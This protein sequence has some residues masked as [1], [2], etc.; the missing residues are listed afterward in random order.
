MRILLVTGKIAEDSLRR[1]ASGSSHEV[2]VHALPVSVA[3]FITPEYAARELSQPWVAGYDMILVPGTVRGDVSPI[4]DATGVPT[5]KGPNHASEVPVVLEHIGEIE[6][7]RT[8]A[9]SELVR[10]ALRERAVSIIDEVEKDWRNVLKEHGGLIIGKEG[11]SVP[12]GRGFPMRIVAEIVNA[13]TLD[14]AAVERRA[15]YYENQGADIVDIGMLAGKS[16][17]G[18]IPDLVDAVRSST[19][20]PVSIDTLDVAEIRAAVESGIDLVLSLDAG[21]MEQV[22]LHIDDTPVVILPTNMREGVIPRTADERVT[23]LEKN[24]SKARGLGINKIIADPVLEP[25]IKPGLMES[26]RAYQLFR[27]GNPDTPVLFGLGNVTELIDADS[28]GVNGLLAALASEVEAELL[29]IPEH[30]VKAR[31]SVQETSDASKMMFLA[32]RNETPPKDLGVDLLI[33]KEKRWTEDEYDRSNEA[34]AVVVDAELEANFAPDERGWFK[35]QV[36]RESS[37]I[38]VS[39]YRE[40]GDRPDAIVRGRNAEEIYQTL[41]REGLIG[42]MEHASY[43]GLE[44]GKAEIALLLGRSYSQDEPLFK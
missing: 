11:R 12:V 21:N 39:H 44:L 19:D 37:M 9:A 32:K 8:S 42:K 6:L 28:P 2:D 24:I 5:F 17:P 35:V 29:F 15:R 4:E 1:Y 34:E 30:S 3:A 33:L 31:G 26:L 43:L 23:L 27:R 10:D 38:V 25:A 40:K 22:A 16:M 7:S 20:L 41:I 14:I 13:P 18:S 36:D